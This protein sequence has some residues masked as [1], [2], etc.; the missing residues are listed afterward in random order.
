MLE[1]KVK[2]RMNTLNDGAIIITQ[3]TTQRIKE[4]KILKDY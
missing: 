3:T 4:I 2:E 1:D